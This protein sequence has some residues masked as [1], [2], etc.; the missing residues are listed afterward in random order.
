MKRIVVIG[1]GII[2]AAIAYRLARAG[3]AVTVVDAEPQSGGRAT[4]ASWAWIN[5]SWG[6]DREYVALRMHAMARWRDVEEDVPSLRL[7]WCGSLLWDLPEDKLQ[8][9]AA[10]HASWG[11]P[12]HM[13]TRHKIAEM[14]PALRNPPEH[15]VH[16][17]IEGAI[18]PQHAAKTFI[19]AAEANGARVVLNAQV[20]KLKLQNG[21]VTG[22]TIDGTNTAAD[23]IVIAAGTETAT[24]LGQLGITL[25]VAGQ[26]GLLIH[27]KPQPRILNSII[28][29]PK[30][31]VRQTDEGKLVAG[32]EFGGTDPT[33]DPEATASQLLTDLQDVLKSSATLEL[34]RFTIGV[35]PTPAD[36]LPVFGRLPAIEGVYIAV[37]HSGVTLAPAIGEIVSDELIHAKRDSNWNRYAPDRLMS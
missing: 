22:V 4:P 32:S 37:M 13:L 27:T 31:H 15:A 23:E 34:D 36:G 25:R 1:A 17:A 16:V 35:R 14:E 18:D 26:P 19:A 10:E 5:A 3:A 9:F 20:T 21:R 24:M 29:S 12:T 8:A 28:L 11:Y 6:N 30:L 7:N 2:G 33:G